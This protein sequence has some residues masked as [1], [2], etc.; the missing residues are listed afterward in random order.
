MLD[1]SSA[2]PSVV[3]R[4]TL[5]ATLFIL[6]IDYAVICT[7]LRQTRASRLLCNTLHS[8]C[9]QYTPNIQGIIGGS[10]AHFHGARQIFLVSLLVL[11]QVWKNSF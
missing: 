6:Q 9:T 3:L 4:L 11:K 5:H 8:V 7:T 2:G 1:T 10:K